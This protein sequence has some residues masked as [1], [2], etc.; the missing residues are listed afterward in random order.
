MWLQS[1]FLAAAK[2][3]SWQYHSEVLTDQTPEDLSTNIIREKLLE[4]LPQEVP[5]SMSQ[6]S[7]QSLQ[8][9]CIAVENRFLLRLY[10]FLQCVEYWQEEE[11]CEL[12]ISVKLYVKKETHMVRAPL[13]SLTCSFYP[14]GLCP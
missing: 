6:V 13:P 11:N 7:S 2:P 1:Y 4:Y 5:Y 14:S 12:H 10:F 9:S 3:G 8:L